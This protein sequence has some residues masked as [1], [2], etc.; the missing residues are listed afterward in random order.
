MALAVTI[1]KKVAITKHLLVYGTLAF[2]GTYP[3]GGEAI[4]LK[5]V[6]G[7]TKDPLFMDINGKAGFQY[8]W[9]RVA[10]KVMIF[11]NSAGG[12]NAALTEHTN[13]AVVAGVT[14][15]TIDFIAF[16]PQA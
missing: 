4:D 10:G 14:G 3:T 11:T 1:L 8:A 6:L 7:K 12:A 13:A 16:V 15:D 2:S 9:D 5:P